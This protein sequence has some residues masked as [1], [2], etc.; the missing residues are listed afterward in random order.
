MIATCIETSVIEPQFGLLCDRQI[1]RF[2]F[3]Q[4]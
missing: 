1:E 2:G 4:R 3:K